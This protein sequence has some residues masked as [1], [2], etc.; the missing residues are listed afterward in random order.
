MAGVGKAPKGRPLNCAIQ[1]PPRRPSQLSRPAVCRINGRVLEI[2]KPGFLRMTR[3]D[4][5]FQDIWVRLI[6]S[7]RTLVNMLQPNRSKPASHG[8][9]LE[10]WKCSRHP[11]R[12]SGRHSVFS[13]TAIQSSPEIARDECRRAPQPAVALLPHSLWLPLRVSSHRLSLAR[14]LPRYHRPTSVLRS[15]G[16]RQGRC[17]WASMISSFHIIF[18]VSATDL[19]P[20]QVGQLEC[21]TVDWKLEQDGHSTLGPRWLLLAPFRMPEPQLLSGRIRTRR[22][23]TGGNERFSIQKYPELPQLRST[24]PLLRY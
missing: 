15:T 16:T 4:L 11:Q 2:P 9:S 24:K 23:R 22:T 12:G 8:L 6:T 21:S 1:K 5:H 3:I 10:A 18:H 7:R 13:F 17:V 14:T 20:L 19:H